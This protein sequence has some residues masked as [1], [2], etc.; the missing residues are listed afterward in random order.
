MWGDLTTY[1]RGKIKSFYDGNIEN[2]NDKVIELFSSSKKIHKY[3]LMCYSYN[4]GVFGRTEGFVDRWKEVYGTKP[5]SIEWKCLNEISLKYT[6]FID[7][8]FPGLNFKFKILDEI[9]LLVVNNVGYLKIRTVDGAL[10]T[11]RFYKKE[12][13]IRKSFNP[14]NMVSEN[15]ALYTSITDKEGRLVID[16]EQFKLKFRSYLIHSVDAGVIR[17]IINRMYDKHKYNCE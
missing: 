14:H 16:V 13:K 4:Q 7:E 15:Y 5:N 6:K 10:I 9:V 2:K 1:A 11:W 3:A 17:S 8:I 12:R